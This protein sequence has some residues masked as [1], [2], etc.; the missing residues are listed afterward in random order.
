MFMSVQP[1]AKVY[2]DNDLIITIENSWSTDYGLGIT[3][4]VVSKSK[5]LEKMEVCVDD[6]RVTAALHPR[7]DIT[8]KHSD[9][10]NE[11]YGFAV[12][13]PRLGKHQAG[14]NIVTKE[15]QLLKTVSFDGSHPIPP[16][17]FAQG[18]NL[19]NE[20]IQIVNENQLRVLEIGSRV[21]SPGSISK[22]VLFPNAASYTGFDYYPDNNTDVVG[23]AHRLSSYF[24]NQRFDAIFSISVF[25]HLAMPWIVA[26]E[27]NQLL[28][29]GGVT[30][31]MTHNAWPIHETPWDFWR[32]SDEALKV[33]FSPA[34]GFEV[35]EVGYYEPVR[36]YFDNLPTGQELFP[37]SVAF[38]GVAVLARKVADVT[39]NQFNWNV[40]VE[41]VLGLNSYY[42]APVQT[43]LRDRKERVSNPD[44]LQQTLSTSTSSQSSRERIKQLRKKVNHLKLKLENSDSEIAALKE[45]IA[46]MQSSKFWKLRAKWIRW[47]QS[48]GLQE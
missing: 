8:E 31:H 22:R 45:E 34:L 4:W 39:P 40:S 17:G 24:G 23:D 14:F 32:F 3:G 37:H 28:K 26:K 29:V 16:Q 13:I 19:F 2:E 1:E 42:P 48:L 21:V 38:G 47:K 27:I 41:E 33:L 44:S 11:V 6:A 5:P 43:Q 9:Y 10:S 18:G 36:I 7:P 25:E 30:L 35:L 20:F 12:Q 15:R 46:A